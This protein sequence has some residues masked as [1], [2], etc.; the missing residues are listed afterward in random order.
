M[1]A[2]LAF[3]LTQ[4]HNASQERDRAFALATRNSAVTEFLD[5]LITEAAEANQPVT[6]SD[7]LT[8]GETLAL[9]DRTDDPESR[10]AVLRMLRVLQARSAAASTLDEAVAR[11]DQTLNP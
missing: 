6:V 5:M 1:C 11:T 7:M 3:A 10:A 4:A 9:A 8:R 2:A